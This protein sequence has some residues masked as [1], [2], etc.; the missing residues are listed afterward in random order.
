ML[1]SLDV[2]L[3]R[4]RAQVLRIVGSGEDDSAG[5]IPFT[6]RAKKVLELAM[7]ES[8]SL[9]HN[10]IGTEHILLG[11]A[12]EGE[13]VAGRDPPRP[14]R[15]SGDDPQRGDPDAVR[16]G[17]AVRRP[18]PSAGADDRDLA[19]GSEPAYRAAGRRDPR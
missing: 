9:G 15:R 16:T 10:H 7:R 3:E 1:E 14:R 19:R 13:G 18:P 5:Q 2:T 6:P 17:R 11:L 12:R 4:V 8:M